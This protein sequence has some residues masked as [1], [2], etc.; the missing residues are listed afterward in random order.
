MHFFQTA[1]ENLGTSHFAQWP[2]LVWLLVLLALTF[3][4]LNGMHD[5]AN[6]VATVVSTRVLS[7]HTAVVWAAFFNFVAFL[8]FPLHVADT[9]QKD[10]VN[11]AIVDNQFIAATLLAACGW[12]LLTWYFGL[13]TSS[14]HALIGG[15][16]GAALV[17]GHYDALRWNGLGWIVLFIILAPMIGPRKMNRM[18]PCHFPPLRISTPTPDLAIAA[19]AIDATSACD[20]L[21]GS[22]SSQVMIFQVIAASRAANTTQTLTTS[23]LTSPLEI[24]ADT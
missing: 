13:P 20:E 18:I 23:G 21:V 2:L 9:I 8:V 5:A 3:D 4:F 7:P 22:A 14:S 17:T 19:P 12:N 1:A 16:V 24:V 10:V 11:P 15:M 6:S